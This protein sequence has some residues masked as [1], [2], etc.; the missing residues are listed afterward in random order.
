[1]A[2][3]PGAGIPDYVT[4]YSCEYLSD[5]GHQAGFDAKWMSRNFA[6]EEITHQ[7]KICARFG[8]Y[9]AIKLVM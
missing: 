4:A 5:G 2:S 1:M 7:R 8:H 6:P 3:E 9:M